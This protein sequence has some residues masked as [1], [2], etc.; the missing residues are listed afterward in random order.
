ML[1]VLGL[2][3]V[4]TLV[5]VGTAVAQ[6]EN[7]DPVGTYQFSTFADNQTITGTLTISRSEEGELQALLDAPD[8]DLPHL[9]AVSV[10]VKG[11]EVKLMIPMGQEGDLWIEV[12]ID[13]DD[14]TGQWFVGMESGEITGKRVDKGQSRSHQQ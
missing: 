6:T 11:K 4:M 13:G 3:L 7:V 12:T 14:V 10:E 8:A 9:P 2:W 1:R 5:A